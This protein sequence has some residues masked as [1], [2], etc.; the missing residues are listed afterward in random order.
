MIFTCLALIMALPGQAV[1][2]ESSWKLTV[3]GVTVVGGVYVLFYITVQDT[4]GWKKGHYASKALINH[5]AEGWH[6]GIPQVKML[7]G[8]DSDCVT[9]ID[10]LKLRF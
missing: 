10:I 5:G 9:H 3:S 1:S 6:V 2:A 8:E 4:I 7:E